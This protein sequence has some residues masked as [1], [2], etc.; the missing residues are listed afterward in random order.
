MKQPFCPSGKP[1]GTVPEKQVECWLFEGFCPYIGRFQLDLIGNGQQIIPYGKEPLVFV[2]TFHH[3]MTVM[4][5]LFHALTMKSFGK[6][7]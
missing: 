2:P 5:F 1:E 6:G 3:G 7:S 4:V